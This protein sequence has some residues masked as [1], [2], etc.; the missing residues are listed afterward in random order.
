MRRGRRP[1]V[2]K[3]AVASELVRQMWAVGNIV[4]EELEQG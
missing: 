2:A 1:N 4:R 3:V